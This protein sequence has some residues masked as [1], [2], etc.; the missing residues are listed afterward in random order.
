MVVARGYGK[1]GKASCC[2]VSIEFQF[3]R[4]K[5]FWRMIA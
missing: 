5:T 2:L 1:K 4:M 3:Y